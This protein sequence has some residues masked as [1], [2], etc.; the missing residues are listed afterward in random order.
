V[1][2]TSPS[3]SSPV[4]LPRPAIPVATLRGHTS[5]VL[6]LAVSPDGRT[7]ATCAADDYLKFWNVFPGR[8]AP[9]MVSLSPVKNRQRSMK[10]V[11]TS[12][13]KQEWSDSQLLSSS[14]DK[15]LMSECSLNYR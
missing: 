4:P 2:D 11:K 14:V 13:V 7:V 15:A 10:T 9:L 3:T 12:A 8:N 6:H 5:R 1:W